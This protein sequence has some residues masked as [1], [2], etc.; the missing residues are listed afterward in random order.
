MVHMMHQSSPVPG[1]LQ[2]HREA[3]RDSGRDTRATFLSTGNSAA[4]P[5]PGKHGGYSER[6]P[7]FRE[8]EIAPMHASTPPRQQGGGINVAAG[9]H[10]TARSMVPESPL[11]TFMQEQFG[12]D[13][14]RAGGSGARPLV[15]G[16][17]AGG[18][19]GAGST[20]ASAA[21]GLAPVSMMSPL[22]QLVNGGFAE[23][24]DA[25]GEAFWQQLA[26]SSAALDLEGRRQL[27]L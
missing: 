10:F 17:S 27:G 9:A 12:E 15:G 7:M 8:L 2:H 22:S 1:S 21:S 3:Q 24:N 26:R 14:R 5:G 25:A 13:H 23:E 6:P 19:A 16:V 11:G 4:G 20:V 18:I